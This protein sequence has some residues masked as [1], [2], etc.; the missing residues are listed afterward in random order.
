MSSDSWVVMSVPEVVPT[1]PF[2]FNTGIRKVFVPQ[3]K[4]RTCQ[5][6]DYVGR[7][8]D[9]NSDLA[10]FHVFLRNILIVLLA[11][12]DFTGGGKNARV[13]CQ[14]IKADVNFMD[15]ITIKRLQQLQPF[16]EPEH[17][18]FGD[19]QKVR[20]LPKELGSL[21]PFEKV[22]KETIK[23]TNK[24]AISA[25]LTSGQSEFADIRRHADNNRFSAIEALQNIWRYPC[26]GCS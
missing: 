2:A 23:N 10:E 25:T 20:H 8:G 3:L 11:C 21:P 14:S 4:P 22:P 16:A 12:D 24:Q 15:R 7:K 6:V 9:R 17:L 18:F 19:F 1:R 26:F 5:V 13:V